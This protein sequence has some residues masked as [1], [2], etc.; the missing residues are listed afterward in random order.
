MDGRHRVLILGDVLDNRRGVDA[1]ALGVCGMT[2]TQTQ[3]LEILAVLQ[4]L[5]ARR[6]GR[7]VFVLG[8]RDVENV[9]GQ[10]AASCRT[11][12]PAYHVDSSTGEEYRT[13]DSRGGF[14]AQHKKHMQSHFAT[15]RVVAMAKVVSPAGAFLALHGGLTNAFLDASFITEAFFMNVL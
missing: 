5:A 2:G 15:L 9:L 10:Q 12:A 1:D 8:N 4:R 14:S 7:V 6:G 11:Y 3:L 13:C